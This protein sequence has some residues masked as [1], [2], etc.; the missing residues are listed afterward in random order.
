VGERRNELRGL[1]CEE[2]VSV[3]R[4]LTERICVETMKVYHLTIQENGHSRRFV[5]EDRDQ[6]LTRLADSIA[7]IAWPHRTPRLNPEAITG[8]RRSRRA[9]PLCQ[10]LP[11]GDA[12]PRNRPGKVATYLTLLAYASPRARLR[13]LAGPPASIWCNRDRSAIPGYLLP[14]AFRVAQA[15]AE[16]TGRPPSFEFDGRPPSPPQ[17]PILGLPAQA[18][19]CTSILFETAALPRRTS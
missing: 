6:A 13:K 7:N 9:T 11:G 10:Q 4:E 8:F 17:D 14:P 18:G 3:E 1:H 2:Q 15:S 5:Y 12:A 19:A 16:A